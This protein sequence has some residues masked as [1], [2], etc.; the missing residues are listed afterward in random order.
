MP[1]RRHKCVGDR[2][3]DRPRTAPCEAAQRPARQRVAPVA[4]VL[5]A[6]S[7]RYRQ[8]NQN[9][10]RP[11]LRV[12]SNCGRYVRMHHHDAEREAEESVQHDVDRSRDVKHGDHQQRQRAPE[13]RPLIPAEAA[14]AAQPDLLGGYAICQ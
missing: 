12:P 9:Q 3:P 10:R 4:P 13:E 7:S 6:Y 1:R 14:R 2:T 8:Q 5:D 11:E